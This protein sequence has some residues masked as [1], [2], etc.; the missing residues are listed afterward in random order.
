MRAHLR[1][2]RAAGETRVAAT[3]ESIKA[4]VKLGLSVSVEPGAGRAA[5]FSDAELEAAGATLTPPEEDPAQVAA[6]MLL[7]V[8]GVTAE[9]ARR[10]PEGSAVVGF[11]RAHERLEAVQALRDRNVTSLAMELIPRISR[12]QSMDALSSQ[13]SIAGYRAALIVAQ[14]LDKYMPLL[15]TA[16]GTITPAK[17]VVM[18]AGVAGLQAI[19]TA[20]RLGAVVDVSD[21]RPEVKEQVQSLGGRFIEL[22]ELESGS[23]EGGYAREV[24]E[25]FLRKQ[26]AIVHDRIVAADAVITTANVPGRRAPTL[27]TEDMVQQMRNGSVIVDLAVESG[28]NCELTVAG[29]TVERHGVI[30]VG[31]RN[32]PATLAADASRLYARNVQALLEHLVEDGELSLD[33]EDEIT[34]STLL[35]HG[36]EVMHGPTAELLAEREVA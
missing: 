9:E 7:T 14:H 16:A 36:G 34:R 24:S 28:G 13:A 27:V 18:G 1:R 22:E 31:T 17:I 12:A 10:L 26:Q 11:L 15:M 6:D 21:I 30:I 19:A 25:E 29:E 8:G 3:P 2:E 5:S 23:G 35:T 4:L 32:L 20:R 33:L